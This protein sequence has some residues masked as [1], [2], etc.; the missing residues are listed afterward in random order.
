MDVSVIV[1]IYNGREYIERCCKQI[2]KQT[3][4][5]ME[6]ILINDGSTDGSDV[7]CRQMEKRYHNCIFVD[8]ANQGVSAARNNGITYAHGEYIG[9]VD[10]DDEIDNDMFESLYQAALTNDLDVVS[11]EQFGEAG[12]LYVFSCCEEWM[13]A[14]FESKI[15]MSVWN[16]L[17]KRSLI[18]LPFFPVGK[19]I[20]EDLCATYKS[21]I[22]AE[23][24]GVLNVHKYHYIHR[25][26]SSSRV[27]VFNEK[28]FDAIDIADWIYND[29]KIRFPELKDLNEARKARTYL[30]IS[31]IYYLRKS[32]DEYRD[33]INDMK[34]YLKGLDQSKMKIYFKDKD[35]IRY[36]LYLY[37]MP[38]F[39]LLIKTLDTK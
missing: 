15:K 18:Q 2:A 3:L 7:V 39:K 11:M 8:Q 28:Y 21:L 23:K 14:F 22:R 30:R 4:K 5:N 19:R 27:P 16:K 25:E 35:V 17:I 26:G 36:K 29:A 24:V 12:E 38:A 6:F 33:R 13:R 34:V 20:H 37:A 1:P 10:V 9:F 31:K 32:P